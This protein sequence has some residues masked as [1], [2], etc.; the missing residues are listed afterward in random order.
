MPGKVWTGGEATDDD[1]G[2]AALSGLFHAE[3]GMVQ[4]VPIS[5][6][7]LNLDHSSRSG[8]IL[9]FLIQYKPSYPSEGRYLDMLAV[10]PSSLG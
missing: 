10:P 1:H 3:I 5:P 8:I 2:V 9:F 7:K 6:I 4:S